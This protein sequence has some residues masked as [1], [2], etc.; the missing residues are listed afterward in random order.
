MVLLQIQLKSFQFPEIS[1][2]KRINAGQAMV[3]VQCN[4]FSYFLSPF[5]GHIRDAIDCTRGAKSQFLL[6]SIRIDSDIS[7]I[8]SAIVGLWSIAVA[9]PLYWSISFYRE[10]SIHELIPQNA[11]LKER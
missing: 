8:P 10:D 6:E 5:K 9:V 2:S 3:E 1:E 7:L 4:F 11:R